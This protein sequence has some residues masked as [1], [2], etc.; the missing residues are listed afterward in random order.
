MDGTTDPLARSVAGRLASAHQIVRAWSSRAEWPMRRDGN[1]GATESRGR[2]AWS[3]SCGPVVRR[4]AAG[5]VW[6]ASMPRSG[7]IRTVS[8]RSPAHPPSIPELPAA[9]PRAC[10]TRDRPQR[11]PF[12]THA[13]ITAHGT[14]HT[15]THHQH[16]NRPGRSQ[17][18]SRPVSVKSGWPAG[19]LAAYPRKLGSGRLTSQPVAIDCNPASRISCVSRDISG[20]TIPANGSSCS[21]QYV[22]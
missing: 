11:P 10:I 3:A 12:R 8:A 5:P 9:V 4:G 17:R 19:R 2:V 18:S 13:R 16:T 15:H 22:K 14:N 21:R 1:H 6:P 7:I 20:D